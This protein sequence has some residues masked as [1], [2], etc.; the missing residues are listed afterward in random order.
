MTRSVPPLL[1]AD[2]AD[3]A[4]TFAE[5]RAGETLTVYEVLDAADPLGGTVVAMPR[6]NGDLLLIE[7]WGDRPL[8]TEALLADAER[9]ARALEEIEFHT[10]PEN[11][12][13]D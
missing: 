12:D 6:G 7:T 5:V 13:N 9:I 2:S 10:L 3:G 8:P 1:I 4:R 11:R